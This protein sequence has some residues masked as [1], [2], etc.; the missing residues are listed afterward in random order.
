MRIGIIISLITHGILIV[1]LYFGMPYFKKDLPSKL[2]I[3]PV[4]MVEIS[5]KTITK[6]Q[7]RKVTTIKK[8]KKRRDKKKENSKPVK[9]AAPKIT[10]RLKPKPPKK[11]TANIIPKIKPKAVK[12]KKKFSLK[13]IAALLDK[14]EPKETFAD[15]LQ[16]RGVNKNKPENS[17][18]VK[19]EQASLIDAIRIHLRDNR[20]WSMLTGAKDAQDMIIFVKVRLRLSGE[21]S[22]V[23]TIKDKRGGQYLQ[24]EEAAVRAVRKCAPYDF[25]PKDKYNLWQNVI[26][27]FNPAE[28]LGN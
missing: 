12:K 14:R 25:L 5:D 10:P 24:A 4:E 27:K 9:D 19:K 15:K 21:L 11:I 20:C 18:D 3:I 28:V 2:R 8:K 1:G 17:I 26:L 7:P 16:K 23:P 13:R 6:K 22:D